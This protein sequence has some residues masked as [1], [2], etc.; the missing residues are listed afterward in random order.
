VLKTIPSTDASPDPV[1]GHSDRLIFPAPA[2]SARHWPLDPTLTFL[3]HGSYGSVPK[4]ALKIQA[5]YRERMEADPVRFFKSDLE[6]LLDGVR[7]SLGSFLN[8]RAADLALVANA[9]IA[10]CTILHTTPLRPGDEVLITDHEYQSLLNEMERITARTGAVLVK[11]PVPFPI[12]SQQDV[13]D[14]FLSAITPRTRIAFISHITSGTSLV[15]PVAQVVRELNA[16]SIDVVVDGAH[17]PGQIPVDIRALN[18]TYFVGSGHK[19]LSGP[20]GTGFIYVRPDRQAQF[21]P[22]WLSSRVN[23]VRP[24]R[25]LFLRDFDYHGTDDYSAM[26]TLPHAIEAMGTILPGGWPALMRSN[27]DL[28]LAGRQVLLNALAGI[29]A[30]CDLP[31][32]EHMV[33]TMATLP[34]P[35]PSPEFSD[36]PTHYDDA[37][38]DA[39]LANHNIVV[40]IWR[41]NSDQRVIRFST[42]LYNSLDQYEKLAHALVTELAK[43]HKLRATG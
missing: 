14:S 1:S 3:N 36:R 12:R 2:G 19:W 9:T 32:P 11:A 29:G 23:K 26:L 41:L 21:R 17:S 7:Q 4:V 35:E 25:S 31:A 18:P 8:C 43:E 5:L 30:P 33:G 15:F 40:P 34:I 6:G 39:L 13:V 16:R 27:H 22:L 24:E 20:K 28:I 37:L 10:L 38:Q 42:Q